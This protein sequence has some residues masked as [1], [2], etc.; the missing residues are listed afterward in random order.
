[1]WVTS[2]QRCIFRVLFLQLA[3]TI[4]PK[5]MTLRIPLLIGFL[6]A[7]MAPLLSQKWSQK[8]TKIEVVEFPTVP[9]EKVS[10]IAFNLFAED[11]YFNLDDLRRYGGNMDLLKSGNE[12]LSG[13]KYFTIGAEA[14]VV[15]VGPS[16]MVDVAIGS[17]DQ[18]FPTF[19][20]EPIKS[21][22]EELTYWAVV[23][24]RLPMRVR[25]ASPEGEVWDAFEVD[26][27]LQIR[28]GNEKI[29]TRSSSKGSFSYSKGS[30]KFDTEEALRAGLESEEGSR[31]FRRKAVL[32]QL[33]NV[34]NELETR[35]FFLEGKVEVTVYSGRGK[36]DYTELDAARDVAM[37][38]YAN[39]YFEG[40]SS[41][42]QTWKEWAGKVDFTDKKAKV[43]RGLA[44]GMRLNL[45]QAH[46]Y[47]DEFKECAQA[48]S[49]ARAL[50]L[51]GGEEFLM[52]ERLQDGLMKRRRALEANGDFEITVD[53]EREKA[54][55]FKNV[56]G[57]RS[58]NK[59]VRMIQP[60]D[61]YDAIG[62]DM[63]AWA[64]VAVAGSPEAAAEL[65]SAVTMEQRLGSRLQQTIGGM[66]LQLSPLMD[67][68]LVGE[69]FPEEI[70]AIPNLVYLDISGMK[71]GAIPDDIDRLAVLQTLVVSRN[72]LEEVPQSLGNLTGLKKLFLSKN[73][74]TG[75][76]ASLTRCTQLK[77]L[78]LKGNPITPDTVSQLEQMFGEEV[79]V[80]HD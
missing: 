74:L 35:L 45:A 62:K 37:E 77:M 14:E 63:E 72:D 48:I 46:L 66:M 43:T 10:R 70:L 26:Q 57:K 6:F 32:L 23:P 49:D 60:E 8:K 22:S 55:D 75:L 25:I 3:K 30:L 58:E 40:L 76:P 52:L 38:S 69:E 29:S 28:Y 7:F 67:P 13:M 36:H 78:D 61:R 24:C 50:V 16:I 80:K 19:S 9:A 39:G 44:L 59:D 27:P 79:K 47:R 5:K 71:F 11:A 42:I 64:S 68:D 1:M 73:E 54:P 21:G 56:I 4:G 41:P 18:G 53:A 51:P 33:S 17:E 20:S 65:T 31:F 34:I 15:D 2:E 12:R